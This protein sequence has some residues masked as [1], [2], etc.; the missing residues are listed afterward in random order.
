LWTCRL[1]FRSSLVPWHL[2]VRVDQRPSRHLRR[3]LS[4]PSWEG[5]PESSCRS[6]MV[7]PLGCVWKLATSGNLKF[8]H[9]CSL[10]TGAAVDALGKASGA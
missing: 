7:R 1:D 4:E 3:S 8:D 9:D 10:S 2:A 5:P 6:I